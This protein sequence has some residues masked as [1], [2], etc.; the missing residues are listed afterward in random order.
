M[1]KIEIDI[2]NTLGLTRK[3]D[4]LGRIVLPAE[5]RNELGLK[6]KDA[7]SVYLLDNGFYVKKK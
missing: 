6:S 1:E 3:I 2:G 5:F 4:D 7:V